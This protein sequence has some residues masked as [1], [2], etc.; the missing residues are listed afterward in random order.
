MQDPG[1]SVCLLGK[2]PTKPYNGFTLE[3]AGALLRTSG[4]DTSG[5]DLAIAATWRAWSAAALAG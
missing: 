5:A 1:Y 3:G 4:R 2:R